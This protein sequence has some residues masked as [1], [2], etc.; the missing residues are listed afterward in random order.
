M[1]LNIHKKSF[2]LFLNKKTI[3]S[4]LNNGPVQIFVTKLG[5]TCYQKNR[6]R[7]PNYKIRALPYLQEN[8]DFQ[9]YQINKN[10][11]FQLKNGSSSRFTE[12]PELFMFLGRIK[13]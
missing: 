10:K 9:C 4:N 11:K 5:F 3:S 8:I 7:S 1:Q 12:N 6:S 2:S 13:V